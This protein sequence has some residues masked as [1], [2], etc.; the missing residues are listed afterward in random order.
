MIVLD[1]RER[2]LAKLLNPAEFESRALA[3]ADVLILDPSGNV[4]LAIERKTTAD[5]RASLRDGR[6]SEQRTRMV[7][8]YGGRAVYVIEG[9]DGYESDLAGAL[10]GVT[11][12]SG[13][14][15]VKTKDIQET[16]AFIKHVSAAAAKGRLCEGT[17]PSQTCI[18]K[19]KA[20]TGQEIGSAMLAA[21]PGVSTRIADDLIARFGSLKAIIEHVTTSG[22][23]LQEEKVNGRRLGKVGD[24]ITAVLTQNL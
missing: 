5:L 13:I 3:P 10:T 16:I 24:K 1:V 11:F 17:A 15:T 20:T 4:E 18:P 19:R 7:E 9:E 12:R 6:F 23:S 2:D 22:R 8:A 14:T 21:I